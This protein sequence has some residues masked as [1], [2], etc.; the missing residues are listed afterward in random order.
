MPLHGNWEQVS[1][2]MKGLKEDLLSWSQEET[3]S[4]HDFKEV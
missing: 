3:V 2:E 4:K 1:E